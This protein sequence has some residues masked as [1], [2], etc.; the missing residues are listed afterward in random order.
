MPFGP[1]GLVI[2]TVLFGRPIGDSILFELDQCAA[3]NR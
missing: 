2:M 3:L 1:R